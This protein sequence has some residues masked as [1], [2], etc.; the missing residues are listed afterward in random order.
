MRLLWQSI[1]FKLNK[2]KIVI[3]KNSRTAIAAWKILRSND[4]HSTSAV[5]PQLHDRCKRRKKF[6]NVFLWYI[7]LRNNMIIPMKSKIRVLYI[8]FS[9]L[10]KYDVKDIWWSISMRSCL[11]CSESCLIINYKCSIFSQIPLVFDISNFIIELN[12]L[13]QVSYY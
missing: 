4:V 2:K 8:F 6:R 9:V 5:H 10:L 1:E 3:L 12:I 13:K 11:I 7:Y